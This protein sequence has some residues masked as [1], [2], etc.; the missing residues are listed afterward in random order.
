MH[1]EETISD[2][3]K[4]DFRSDEIKTISE[5]FLS[6]NGFRKKLIAQ[7]FRINVKTLSTKDNDSISFLSSFAHYIIVMEH[8]GEIDY[9]SLTPDLRLFMFYSNL[10]NIILHPIRYTFSHVT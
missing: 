8:K 6:N 10:I 5:K 9:L 4:R 3:W 1:K 7:D 2:I